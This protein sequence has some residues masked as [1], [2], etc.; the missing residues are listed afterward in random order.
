MSGRDARSEGRAGRGNGDRGGRSRGRGYGYTSAK[1]TT[2][3]G[4]CAALGTHV[5]D[6][7]HK[8]AADQMRTTWEKLA[9]YCGTINGQDILNELTNKIPVIL[10]EPV[11]TQEVIA[12]H[13]KHTKMLRAVQQKLQL[14]R[15]NEKTKL[16]VWK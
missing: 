8:A 13:Q 1:S 3:N 16:D 9:Q 15:E 6:Y 7:G 2:N 5:F 12:H 4:L 10:Q 11:Y 14:A